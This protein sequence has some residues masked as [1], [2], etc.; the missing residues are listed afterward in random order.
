MTPTKTTKK[1]A[2][3]AWGRR[4]AQSATENTLC[5]IIDF[6]E[7]IMLPYIR[8]RPSQLFFLS[9]PCAHVGGVYDC[10]KNREHD[11][12]VRLDTQG[13]FK[14]SDGVVRNPGTF[15]GLNAAG[16]VGGTTWPAQKCATRLPPMS[17]ATARVTSACESK[18]VGECS[19]YHARCP[20]C[21]VWVAVTAVPQQCWPRLATH[22][23]V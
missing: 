9:M 19:A 20:V 2:H 12:L 6:S 8:S 14:N 3:D 11:I 21:T 17:S 1:K 5:L 23:K 18:C 13:S 7:S 4:V 10:S 16:A 15:V 22:A